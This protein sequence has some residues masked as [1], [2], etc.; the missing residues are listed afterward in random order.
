MSKTTNDRLL[1]V[2]FQAL[3]DLVEDSPY[4]SD[5]EECECGDFIDDSTCCHVRAHQAIARAEAQS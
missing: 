3:K 1:A 4:H 5:A 2:L